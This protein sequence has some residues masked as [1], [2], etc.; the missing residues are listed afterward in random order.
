MEGLEPGPE[1]PPAVAKTNS[2][3]TQTKTPPYSYIQ[4]IK[5]PSELGMSDAGNMDAIEN[6]LNGLISYVDLLIDG[7]SKASKAE[8]NGALGDRRFIE[9]TAKCNVMGVPVTRSI[10]VDNVPKGGIGAAPGA[11]LPDFKGLIPGMMSGLD[12]LDP[13]R[14]AKSI[15]NT[16][17]PE[18]ISVTLNV[19]DENY[20]TVPATNYITLVD[21]EYIDPCSFTSCVNPVTKGTCMN[22]VPPSVPPSVQAFTTRGD[23][24][25]S[26]ISNDY[27]SQIFITSVG[28]MGI[29]ILHLLLKNRFKF[30]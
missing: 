23:L 15:G 14:M 3:T 29:F 13:E 6:N 20:N 21:A 30:K 12:S 16:D 5:A 18:C 2:T 1:P 4:F 26:E 19:M 27:V 25:F 9:T 7:P 10:Y 8:N 28:I 24:L 22:K 17:N 11:N